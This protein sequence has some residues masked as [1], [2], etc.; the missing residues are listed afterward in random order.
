L[1]EDGSKRVDYLFGAVIGIPSKAFGDLFVSEMRGSGSF[2]PSSTR[3][4]IAGTAWSTQSGYLALRSGTSYIALLDFLPR[5]PFM[6]NSIP[7]I[8]A[9]LIGVGIIVIGCFYLASPE[10]GSGTF[11]LEPP[12]SDADARA[13]VRPK[14]IRDIASGLIVL[15]MMQ[16]ETRLR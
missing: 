7:L 1:I 12:A 9:V 16:A 3:L 6:Y 10:R 13:W 14:G 4:M 11:G 5:R 15:T 8:L 2:R